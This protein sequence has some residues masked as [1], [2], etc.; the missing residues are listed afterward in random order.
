MLQRLASRISYS[1]ILGVGTLLGQVR[2]KTMLT[3]RGGLYL[4]VDGLYELVG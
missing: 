1:S 3:R 4:V 2:R